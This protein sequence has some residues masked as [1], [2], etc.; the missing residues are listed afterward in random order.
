ML[1]MFGLLVIV[2][3]YFFRFLWLK[4]YS[5]LFKV[6]LLVFIRICFLVIILC[7]SVFFVIR[8]NVISRGLFIVISVVNI[9]S[10]NFFCV[11][12]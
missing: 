11:E 9:I 6:L 3:V 4:F 1:K 2:V 8:K 12:C 5:N 10:R 7:F